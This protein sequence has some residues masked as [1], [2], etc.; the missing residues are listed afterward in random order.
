MIPKEFFLQYTTKLCWIPSGAHTEYV[1]D[2]RHIVPGTMLFVVVFCRSASFVE[3]SYAFTFDVHY[4]NI[5]WHFE[6]NSCNPR[7]LYHLPQGFCT[8]Q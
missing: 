8:L 6:P 2:K 1:C 4:K 7:I 3:W 5:H